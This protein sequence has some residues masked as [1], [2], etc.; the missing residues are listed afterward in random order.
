[1]LLTENLK[2]VRVLSDKLPGGERI[3][4]G[5]EI[6]LI[7]RFEN[8]KYFVGIESIVVTAVEIIATEADRLSHIVSH[9]LANRGKITVVFDS[10]TQDDEKKNLVLFKLLRIQNIK[11]LENN[12]EQ[13]VA[14]YHGKTILPEITVK[15]KKYMIADVM[16]EILV[17][18]APLRI[19]AKYTYHFFLK[20]KERVS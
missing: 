8:L 9:C 10:Q 18:I 4:K 14:E 17:K 13:I 15:P 19:F 20:I 1:M 2:Q 11:L 12:A 3:L 6:G 16:W 7:N 5:N